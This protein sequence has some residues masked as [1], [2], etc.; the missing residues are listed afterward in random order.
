MNE[1]RF[2]FDV[3]VN[4]I[5][6]VIDNNLLQ[7]VPLVVKIIP[8]KEKKKYIITCMMVHYFEND[9]MYSEKE[10]NEIMK[11]MVEDYV[12][13][14]RNMV[15]YGFIERKDDGS[16]YWLVADKKQ[17]E[18]YDLTKQETKI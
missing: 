17:Y 15:D 9:R 10:I 18:I 8:A 2:M 12:M 1:V 13:F 6:Q 11:P 3:T 14:R 7:K 16:A 5:K 4:D